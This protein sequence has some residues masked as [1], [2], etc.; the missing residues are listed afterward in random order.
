MF[1][2]R[3]KKLAERILYLSTIPV[4]QQEV[5]IESLNEDNDALCIKVG[6]RVQQQGKMF[7]VFAPVYTAAT[8]CEPEDMDYEIAGVF[9]FLDSA[10]KHCCTL[11]METEIDNLLQADAEYE[12]HCNPIT[13]EV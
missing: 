9:G 10:L 5:T 6:L 11:Y 3:E 8:R 12:A 4:H 7:V 13:E 1:T 2:E